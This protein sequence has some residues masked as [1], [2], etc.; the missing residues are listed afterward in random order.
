VGIDIGG[1]YMKKAN[2]VVMAVAGIVLLIAA[3][4]KTHQLLT[5]PVIS[6]SF[7]ESWEFFVI[8]IP[9]E[10]GLGIWLLSGLFKKAGWLL[11]VFAFTVFIGVTA[12]KG[13]IGVESCGCFGRVKVNPW[14]T[15]FIMDIPLLFSLLIFR[16]MGQKILPPPWPSL[17][18]FLSVFI[19]T[20]IILGITVPVLIFNKVPRVTE[21]WQVHPASNQSQQVKLPQKELLPEKSEPNAKIVNTVS[22]PNSPSIEKT[23]A[24]QWP[25][26]NDIDIAD[27]LRKGIIVV[28][29]YHYDCPD[30]AK[31]IPLYDSYS[32]QFGAD[33]NS[34][35]FAFIEIPPYGGT[36]NENPVPPDTLCLDGKINKNKELIVKTPVVVVIWNGVLVK[37]WDEGYAPKLDEIFEA[38]AQ[39]N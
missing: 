33:E 14:I 29:L 23:S 15:L 36:A 31:A 7:W 16:P 19:S 8:Q 2:T 32:R 37:K 17:K 6:K 21:T 9:L 26:L 30:C 3:V 1:Y 25:L 34:M 4:L 12:Y 22:G 11:A 27:T 39:R 24:E 10:I 20:F 28:L 5:E 35:R 18:H 38:V 13:M